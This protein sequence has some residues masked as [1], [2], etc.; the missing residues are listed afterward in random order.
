M[1]GGR[2]A[3]RRGRGSALAFLGLIGETRERVGGLGRVGAWVGDV[4]GGEFGRAH[5]QRGEE[6]AGEGYFGHFDGGNG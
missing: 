2:G 6:G 3:R 4:V 1:L 5:V